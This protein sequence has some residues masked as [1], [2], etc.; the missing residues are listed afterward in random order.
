VVD[1]VRRILKKRGYKAVVES[2]LQEGADEI[3]F[4]RLVKEF[5]DEERILL[6]V[7]ST[8]EGADA[9]DGIGHWVTIT[10]VDETGKKISVTD[11]NTFGDQS[12]N[13]GDPGTA[14][15]YDVDTANFRFTLGYDFLGE[16]KDEGGTRVKV[17]DMV[18]VSD[19]ADETDST[20]GTGGGGTGGETNTDVRGVT[21]RSLAVGIA[22][23]APASGAITALGLAVLAAGAR[24][25]RRPCRAQ[26]TAPRNASP[27]GRECVSSAPPRG[28]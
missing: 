1:G 20:E 5:K 21:G 2:I 23:P 7:E 17:I 11:P 28:R 25:R 9:D 10:G 12:D 3:T 27:R 26:S 22:V 6:L 4:A 18:K 15:T 19:V 16:K 13:P 8:E 14:D 24:R